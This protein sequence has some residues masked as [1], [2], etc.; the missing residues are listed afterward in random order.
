MNNTLRGI[1]LFLVCGFAAAAFGQSICGYAYRKRIVINPAQVAG[2]S[3]LVNFPVMIAISGDNDLRTVANSGRVENASGF[4]IV[5]TAEDGVS[6]L[7]FQREAYSATAGNYT[8]WVR[9]PNLSTSL[10]T[11][12]YMYYGN[13]AVV[14]DQSS[15]ATWSAY[16]AVWHF[17]GGSFA[18]ATANAYNGTNN[19]TTNQANARI[20]NGRALNGTQWIELSGF[21][22][23]N[24]NFAI[25]A[26]IN[27]ASRGTAGQRIFCDDVNNSG[28]YG[29]SL[30]DGGTGILRFYSRGS[31]NVILDSPSNAIAANN[32]WY[33]V[34]AVADVSGNIRR[35]FVN[36]A[37]VSSIA[38]VGWGTDVGNASIGGETASGET[39]NRFN[40]QLDEVRIANSALSADW[41]ATEYNNQNAPGTFYTISAEPRVWIGGSSSNM[42]TA[43][44]WLNST[45]PAADEDVIITNGSNQPVLPSNA[46]Y[47][48]LYIRSGATLSL[49]V[50]TLSVRRD[51]SNCGTL[52]GAGGGITLN[53]SNSFAQIQHLSGTGTYN[54]NNLTVNNTYSSSPQITLGKDVNVSGSLLLTSGIVNTDATNLLAL[55]NSATSSSGS[56]SSYVNGPMSK[57]GTS[58]MVFPVGKS[59]FWRRIGISAPSVASTFRA[60]Y[61]YTVPTATAN[62]TAPLNNISLLEYWQLD[63]L[64]G[65]GNASVSLYWENAGAS[66]I[67]DC[68]DL[69]IARYNGST[70]L[71]LPGT[72]VGASSC[73][74]AGTGTISTDAVV[75]AFSPFTFGSNISIANPLPVE[76]LSFGLSCEEGILSLDWA[77]AS[78]RNFLAYGIEQS[79]DGLS[80][81][82]IKRVKGKAHSASRQTYTAQLNLYSNDL[83]YFRLAMHDLDGKVTYSAP[84][85]ILCQSED[86]ML[87]AYPNPT[88]GRIT[89]EFSNNTQSGEAE[90]QVLDM[91]GRI[92]FTQHISLQE[93][94]H[95]LSVDV[96]QSPGVYLLRLKSANFQTQVLKVVVQ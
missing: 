27:T 73:S 60:E 92:L 56:A 87:Y 20:N 42:S 57:S 59:G 26:W 31:T 17:Q 50:N 41:I 4:D 70:W 48:S 5:F 71:E 81:M 74:G 82:E 63:R 49:S 75:T 24:T 36:G 22:N 91:T 29:F 25:S 72:P 1:A 69:T 28:G 14:T 53:S 12:L 9:V 55:G 32:T 35:L 46:Q 52:D 13:S 33:H 93:S 86:Q 80:W 77:S 16:R 10:N 94:Y 40:G 8:A 44:N 83:M 84:Q 43:S 11:V 7:N 38:S 45:L 34:V 79:N 66:G 58:A 51:I 62:L 2:P 89:V 19:G 85:S 76:L 64:A 61:F 90:L 37:Q 96:I 21:P 18:D 67:N 54:L 3:D 68:A 39:A 47:N 23:L 6:L 15:T 95:R 78:E 65:A 30:G 88:D